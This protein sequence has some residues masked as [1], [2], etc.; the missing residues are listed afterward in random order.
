MLDA[1]GR[2]GLAVLA[3][4]MLGLGLLRLRAIPRDAALTVYALVVAVLGIFAILGTQ[5]AAIGGGILLLVFIVARRSTE[6]WHWSRIGPIASANLSPVRVS[7]SNNRNSYGDC[8][9]QLEHED[10]CGAD[11]LRAGR[12]SPRDGKPSGGVSG[13]GTG[14]CAQRRVSGTTRLAARARRPPFRLGVRRSRVNYECSTM[15][16]FDWPRPSL[17]VTTECA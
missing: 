6:F 7:R 17:P 9:E 2:L 16:K 4:A 13:A 8:N 5:A 1:P 10:R 11:D 14:D 3:A 12:A 15:L